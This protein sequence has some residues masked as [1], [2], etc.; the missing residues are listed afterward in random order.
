VSSDGV[1][2]LML[3]LNFFIGNMMMMVSE[4]CCGDI[5]Q[6]SGDA[7]HVHSALQRFCKCVC[8]FHAHVCQLHMNGAV[9]L[10]A[11]C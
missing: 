6:C 2:A 1:M 7:W 9:M 11:H 10:A 5:M 8:A 3:W 4:H